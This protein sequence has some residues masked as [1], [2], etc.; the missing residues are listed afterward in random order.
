MRHFFLIFI[1]L[2]AEKHFAQE[3]QWA[4]KLIDFTTEWTTGL[5]E[6][7]SNFKARQVLGYPNT[8]VY[9]TS[10]LAWAPEGMQAGK[11]SVV[12]GFD[13]AQYVQ[14]IIIGESYNAGA[15]KEIILYDEKG[16][17][18]TVYENKYTAPKK[19]FGQVLISYK[20]P[21][22]TFKTQKLKL[23]LNT[24]KVGGM[25]Q[26][27]CIGISS[28]T[29]PIKLKVNE[30]YYKEQIA[31]PE[32]LGPNIN[33]EYYDHL[34]ILSPDEQLIY[35][36]RKWAEDNTGKE[37]KDDIYF[38][39]QLNNG[40][41][42][43]AENIGSPLNTDEHNFVCF[44]S[45]DNN[46]LYLANRYKKNNMTGVSLSSKDKYGKWQKP[47]SLSI[48][49][50][51]NN[52]EYAHYHFNLDEDVLLMCVE[53]LD[54]LGDL[55]IFVSFKYTDGTWSKPKNL[56]NTIN[57]I[58][59]EAS[60]FLAAD[61]RTLFFS[62]AGHQGYGSYDMYVSKRLDN[63]WT[64]WSVP[65]NLGTKINTEEIDIYY[66][67]TSNGEYA[68][69]SSGKS[70]F[71]KND[72]YRIKLPKEIQPEPVIINNPQI[73]ANSI[74][75]NNVQPK[76]N[77]QQPTIQ[78]TQPTANTPKTSTQPISNT[79]QSVTNDLQKKLDSLK[80]AQ[81]NP[82][83]II[84]NIPT[85]T[86]T[87]T[88]NNQPKID[89]L[90]NKN[91]LPKSA[92]MELPNT[93]KDSL[94]NN[95]ALPTSAVLELPKQANK[96][97]VDSFKNIP[98]AQNNDAQKQVFDNLKKQPINVNQESG[99]KNQDPTIISQ[100][101]PINNQQEPT[102]IS[103]QQ[104][105]INQQEPINTQQATLKPKQDLATDALAEK[106]AKLKEQQYESKLQGQPKPSTT[107]YS[108]YTEKKDYNNPTIDKSN[109]IDP[110]KN[111]LEQKLQ[112]LNTTVYEE[113]K[114]IENPNTYKP[115][116][117]QPIKEKQEDKFAQQYDEMQDKIA[118][119]KQQ[120]LQNQTNSTKAPKKSDIKV[121]NTNPDIK[122]I[123]KENPTIANTNTVEPNPQVLKYQEKLKQIQEKMGTI[124]NTNPSTKLPSKVVTENQNTPTTAI[125][126]NEP[127][128][129]D[130]KQEITPTKLNDSKNEI[131]KENNSIEEKPNSIEN[132]IAE[133]PKI[134][135]T[136]ANEA[137]LNKQLKIIDDLKKEQEKLNQQLNNTL[138]NLN[139]NKSSLENDIDELAKEREKLNKQLNNTV[140]NLNE[141]K[142]NL[143]KDIDNLSSEKN[144]LDEQKK[145]LE[146]TN[147]KLANEKA[148][149]EQ[150]KK[151]MDELLAQM[152][153]EKDKMAQE[154]AKLE[155][156]KQLLELLRKQQEKEVVALSKNIDSLK[157]TQQQ[158]IDANAKIQRY[159]IFEV[160]IEEGAIAIMKSIYFMADASF[161][162]NKSFPELDKLVAFLKQNPK[163]QKIEIGGH[164]NGLCDDSFC[165]K[166]SNDRAK[167]VMDY[168]IK[169]GIA[170]EKLSFK[171]Y[172]KQFL[173]SKPGDAINQRVEVKIISVK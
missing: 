5:P 34:P 146:N 163:I 122:Y 91:A 153:A 53:R 20:I 76:T 117:K 131:P 59:S 52:N 48:P 9:G 77:T 6:N 19:N 71:G 106:L 144:K 70:Y 67:I 108:K 143:E 107:E 120:Q 37:Q 75:K 3:V 115:Y 103:Q 27:D 12:V 26:I 98:K 158:A 97:A 81:K 140:S 99:I 47:V 161:L 149:L 101:Q 95:S 166:L 111:N 68:Y 118:Q 155:K 15:V 29:A 128:P 167:S 133:T 136:Q 171:G 83:P 105:I 82:A 132:L 170:A 102:I 30:V 164:T 137:E 23:V 1:V 168:L 123:L 61:G 62:S 55:D 8:M 147:T 60:V 24:D 33:S 22:T 58:G 92:V 63:T 121:D 134:N 113:S 65:L 85:K 72:L 159:E 172:G 109:N 110:T 141:N 119:L 41:F 31:N 86:T 2:I 84:N 90:V 13:K 43:K 130:K 129:S 96:Y 165:E 16:K 57:T 162:Q 4:S 54:G 104:P 114:R 7:S 17:G 14:Q 148:K 151:A 39:Y 100:Q 51:Y 36:A 160:P 88:P 78:A 73:L 45:K 124:G 50:M 46:R 35:F 93:K 154:K 18:Y 87:T 32:N 156:D 38:A 94:L 125:V 44:V 28:S 56:G 42:T 126:V 11:E 21:S 116:E 66:T 152:Q 10:P 150:D 64:N 138:T 139:D 80:N 157:K 142:N 79:Q 40:N 127:I 89:T 169:N 173:I 112:D 49:D 74:Q 69:F 135:V 25:Q 145:Q